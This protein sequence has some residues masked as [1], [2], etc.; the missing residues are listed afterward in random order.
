MQKKFDAAQSEYETA[1]R[2]NPSYI[3]AHYELAL[4]LSNQH[5]SA[6]AIAEYRAALKIHGNFS[7][8]LNNLS[9]ILAADPNA[10]LRNGAEAVQLAE[11][12]C[13]LTHNTQAVKVG[14]LAVAYA[15][16]G[17]FDDAVNTAQKAHDL[18]V[19]QGKADLAARDLELLQLF[20][21]R[22]PY[23]EAP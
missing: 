10:Q 8:A 9:W 23:H 13:A 22:R 1:L 5:K 12:A 7:D 18:A 17:R 15:E 3:D 19:A 6:E 2:L 21:A 11:Q 14:T 16:A 20:R 4:A